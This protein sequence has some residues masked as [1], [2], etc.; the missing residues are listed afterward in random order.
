MDWPDSPFWDYSL[1]LYGRPG[2]E[3]ACLELQRR[4]GLD[5]NLLLFSF[6]LA[7][8]GVELDEATLA[9]AEQAV[10]TWHVEVIRPLRALRR[11]LAAQRAQADPKSLLGRWPDHVAKLQKGVLAIE[12]DGEHLAQLALTDIG[13]GLQSTSE[14]GVELA[15]RN[16]KLF[17]HFC[18]QDQD[19]LRTMLLQAFLAATEAEMTS[20][21]SWLQA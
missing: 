8:R 10:S 15:G 16:L 4:H 13:I 12:L 7:D 1:S 3:R 20:A 19:D 17:R 11:R 2:V 18:S 6:W 21:L 5:V 14:P 9:L